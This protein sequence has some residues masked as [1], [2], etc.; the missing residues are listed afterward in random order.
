TTAQSELRG[1]DEDQLVTDGRIRSD[2]EGYRDGVGTLCIDLAG[3]VFAS[4]EVKLNG[5]TIS[6]VDKLPGPPGD[7]TSYRQAV[8]GIYKQLEPIQF[9]AD[10]IKKSENVITLSP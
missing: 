3:S 2:S 8:R 9:D 5:E 1:T 10:L 7:N 4:L 6:A